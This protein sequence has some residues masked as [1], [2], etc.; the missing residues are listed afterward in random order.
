MPVIPKA[1]MATD[2]KIMVRER[3]KPRNVQKLRLS[4]ISAESLKAC[5]SP[6]IPLVEKKREV[7]SDKESSPAFLRLIKVCMLSFT[8]GKAS[9][10][11]ILSARLPTCSSRFSMGK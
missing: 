2:N 11:K 1:I 8:V 4:L 9:G 7:I 6:F 3:D 5:I 10:L